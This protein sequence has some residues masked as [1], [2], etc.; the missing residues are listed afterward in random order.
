MRVLGM[1][2]IALVLLAPTARAQRLA[3]QRG[4]LVQ[5]IEDLFV[6]RV[7]DE[8]GLSSAQAQQLRGTALRIF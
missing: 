4:A 1:A 2:M 5:R 6:Q 3:R 7:T 8:L